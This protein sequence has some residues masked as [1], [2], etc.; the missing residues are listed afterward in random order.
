[1]AGTILFTTGAASVYPHVGSEL[2][3]ANFAVAGACLRAYAHALHATLV[4]SGVQVGHVAIGAWI[5]Q[6]PG[7]TPEAIAPLYWELHTRRDEVE[8][9]FMLQAADRRP[10]DGRPS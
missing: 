2:M 3:F 6:Q 10:V 5:G 4:P 7:A 9:V 8:K 1:R